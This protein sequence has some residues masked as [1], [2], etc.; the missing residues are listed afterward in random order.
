MS[1][2]VRVSL[3]LFQKG[4]EEGKKGSTE[5]DIYCDF[6]TPENWVYYF[7][8][9]RTVP[10]IECLSDYLE[11]STDAVPIGYELESVSVQPFPPPM[12]R[13]AVDKAG[14][15]LYLIPIKVTI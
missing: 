14:K 10:D 13:E 9:D 3:E 15:K 7:D 4:D 8:C 12:I 2:V 6:Q 5:R 11:A 1:F